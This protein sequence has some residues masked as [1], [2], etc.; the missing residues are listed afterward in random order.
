MFESSTFISTSTLSLLLTVHTSLSLLLGVHVLKTPSFRVFWYWLRSAMSIVTPH[1][2][3]FTDAHPTKF[4][5]KSL[6]KITN[7]L[8]ADIMNFHFN[9]NIPITIQNLR[10]CSLYARPDAKGD[11]KGFGWR[12]FSIRFAAGLETRPHSR[13]SPCY[14]RHVRPPVHRYQRGFYE[15]PPTSHSGLQFYCCPRH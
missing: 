2:K 13:H 6:P 14:F 10:P 9:K 7:P 1:L 4:S 11:R 15:F 12:L 5:R 8:L 3:D